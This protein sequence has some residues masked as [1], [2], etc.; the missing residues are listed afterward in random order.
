MSNDKPVVE[1]IDN[2]NA[3]MGQTISS[4]FKRPDLEK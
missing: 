1:N 3:N 2:I 4:E